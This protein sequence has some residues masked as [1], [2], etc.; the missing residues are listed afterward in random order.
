MPAEVT[1][2]VIVAALLLA[3][4]TTANC[5]CERVNSCHKAMYYGSLTVA[6]VAPLIL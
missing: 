5:P 2:G 3:A 1:K 6:A 4:I